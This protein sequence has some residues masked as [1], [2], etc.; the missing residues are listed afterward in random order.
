MITKK[1]E[2]SVTKQEASTQSIKTG[3]MSLLI[4]TTKLTTAKD[5]GNTSQCC[6]GLHKVT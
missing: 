3:F 6:D 4:T 1:F 2:I 5:K